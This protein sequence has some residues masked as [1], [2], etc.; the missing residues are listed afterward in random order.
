MSEGK[1]RDVS[2]N[3]KIATVICDVQYDF[4]DGVLATQGYDIMMK[5]I[6]NVVSMKYIDLIYTAF[7]HPLNHSFFRAF[8]GIW[9]PHCIEDTKGSQILKNAYRKESPIFNKG[10]DSN[11]EEMTVDLDLDKYDI[12]L[13]CG[14]NL[15][16]TVT[17]QALRIKFKYPNKKVCIIQ[18]CST[19]ENED[20]WYARSDELLDSKINTI[21]AS[22][23]AQLSKTL[24]VNKNEIVS[25]AGICKRVSEKLYDLLKNLGVYK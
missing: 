24:I 23:I 18:D 19:F 14:M 25:D 9:E 3:N 13:I 1:A 22:D 5:N 12:I 16:G 17:E 15:E 7:V 2:V 4:C 21:N 20:D 11:D 10:V 8:G 6:K